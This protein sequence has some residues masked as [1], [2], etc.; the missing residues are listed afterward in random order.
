MPVVVCVHGYTS[1]AQAFNALAR[2]L[3]DRFYIVAM[4]VRGQGKSGWSPTRAYQY[5]DQAGD[6]VAFVDRL[7]L[8]RFMLIATS[9]GGIIAMTYAADHAGRLDALVIT[10]SGREAES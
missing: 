2:H 8:P 7:A 4:D 6:L 1:S 10:D 9:M 3:E 5:A